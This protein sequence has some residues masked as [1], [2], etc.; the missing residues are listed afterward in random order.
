MP[1]IGM[2][3]RQ[4]ER[5]QSPHTATT[6]LQPLTRVSLL[7]YSRKR[8][9][10]LGCIIL[11]VGG[12]LCSGSVTIGMFYAGRVIAGIGA[13]ILAVVVPMYQ[14]EVA[15]AETRGAMMSV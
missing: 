12:A 4:G 11:I 8:T 10:Q 6:Q 9:I 13:G 5:P 15:T 3:G 7:Q 2:D 14:G 1:H